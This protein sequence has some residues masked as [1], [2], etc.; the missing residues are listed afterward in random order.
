MCI[1]CIE[2]L[3]AVLTF[4]YFPWYIIYLHFE[5]SIFMTFSCKSNVRS[6]HEYQE[7]KIQY[8]ILLDKS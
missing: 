2:D 1:V 5:I 3:K 6:T 7:G 4:V 8:C